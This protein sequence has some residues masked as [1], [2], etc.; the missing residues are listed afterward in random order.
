M[1]SFLKC[2][3]WRL[4][5]KKSILGRSICPKCG[6][7]IAWYDNIPLLSFIFLRGR[8]RHCRQEISLQYPLVELIAGLLFVAAFFRLHVFC[9][10]FSVAHS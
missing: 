3:I 2:L 8:C 6:H 1:G 5:I 4:H 10:M 9:S 7:Q